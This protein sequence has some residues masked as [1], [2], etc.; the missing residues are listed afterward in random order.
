M[1]GFNGYGPMNNG[2]MTG[3]G[4]GRCQGGPGRG[5]GMGGGMGRGRGMGLQAWAPAPVAVDAP[6]DSALVARQQAEIEAMRAKL[7]KLESA[8]DE[9]QNKG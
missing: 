5:M 4:M 8:L 9:F 6:D 2:P 3:R 1:P 7:A